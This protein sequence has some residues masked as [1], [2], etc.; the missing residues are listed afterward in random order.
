MYVRLLKRREIVS[1]TEHGE[2]AFHPAHASRTQWLGRRG[3][4]VDVEFLEANGPVLNIFEYILV[5]RLCIL[6]L[7]NEKLR[8]QKVSLIWR[9]IKIVDSYSFVGPRIDD[10]GF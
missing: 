10:Y 5:D 3:T 1:N 6:L 4:I 8:E 2:R 9:Y 7:A